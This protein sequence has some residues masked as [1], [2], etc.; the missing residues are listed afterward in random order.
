MQYTYVSRVSKL[1]SF[2]QNTIRCQLS[3][4]LFI[5]DKNLGKSPPT[6]LS[7][8]SLSKTMYFTKILLLLPKLN[9]Y[10]KAIMFLH[11]SVFV[12]SIYSLKPSTNSNA[13]FSE[14]SGSFSIV[15]NLLKVIIF[16]QSR[17]L[18]DGKFLRYEL[19]R[20]AIFRNKV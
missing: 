3:T 20:Q 15:T 8:F 13:Y 6:V 4:L 10:N 2:L 17:I 1:T 14:F 11:Y 19:Q 5:V 7:V 18:Q 16:F 12:L 9:P